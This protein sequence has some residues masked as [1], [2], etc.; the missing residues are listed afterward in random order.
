MP[1]ETVVTNFP[2]WTMWVIAISQ[3]VFALSIAAIAF[4][5]ISLLGQVKSLLLDVGK[6]TDEINKKVPSMMNNVDATVGNVKGMSDDARTTTGHVTNAVSRVAHLTHMVAGRLESP[7]V[8]S[9]GVISGVV[10]GARAL[11]GRNKPVEEKRRGL[12]GKRK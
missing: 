5:A 9:V 7:L 11:R 12:L 1:E 8:R 4:A 6:M 10:A 2:V 3:I